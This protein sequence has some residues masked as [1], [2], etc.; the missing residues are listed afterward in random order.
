MQIMCKS[1]VADLAYPCAQLLKAYRAYY[2]KLQTQM[3][4]LNFMAGL[5]GPSLNV[6]ENENPAQFLGLIAI[7]YGLVEP[8][9][10]SCE[11]EAQDSMLKH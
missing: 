2:A 6:L 8:Q 4:K 1:M 7:K 10:D 3:I 9:L 5:L 11:K